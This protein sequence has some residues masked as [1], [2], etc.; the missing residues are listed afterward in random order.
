MKQEN[1]KEGY[2]RYIVVINNQEFFADYNPKS[3][4]GTTHIEFQAKNDEEKIPISE[5][6]Y[7]SSFQLHGL[8]KGVDV[9][10]SLQELAQQIYFNKKTK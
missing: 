8:Q 5:T 4:G 10:S 6:G 2:T 7:L 3:Y 9:Q 1:P